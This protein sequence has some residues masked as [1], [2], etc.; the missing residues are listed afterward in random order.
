MPHSVGW[1]FIGHIVRT[2]R[3]PASLQPDAWFCTDP[4]GPSLSSIEMPLL[5]C[6][7]LKMLPAPPL[8]ILMDIA[9]SGFAPGSASQ[10]AKQRVFAFHRR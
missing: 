1:Q 6:G 3:E 2:M 8:A 10:V 7:C 9:A 5:A 4:A